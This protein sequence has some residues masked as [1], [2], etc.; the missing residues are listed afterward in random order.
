MIKPICATAG[1]LTFLLSSVGVAGADPPNEPQRSGV[2]SP[3]PLAHAVK[4]HAHQL[5][6]DARAS[7]Q[8]VTTS[9]WHHCRSKKKGAIIGALIGAAAGAVVGVYIVGEV[10]GVSGTASGAS[11]YVAYWTL[12]LL[13]HLRRGALLRKLSSMPNSRRLWMT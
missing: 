9:Q 12:A 13:C 3:L 6:R 10:S 1:I 7:T 8:M 2:E 11:L 4:V 5:A